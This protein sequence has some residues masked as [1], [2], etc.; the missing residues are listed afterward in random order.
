MANSCFVPT[1]EP[2]IALCRN[3]CVHLQL[4]PAVLLLSPAGLRLLAT[5]VDEALAQLDGNKRSAE[6]DE[7]VN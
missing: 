1:I 6:T 7:I 3:G 2:H 4:G 5:A